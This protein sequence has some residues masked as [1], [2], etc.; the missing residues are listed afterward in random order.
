MTLSL[1]IQCFAVA[2]IGWALQTTLKMRALQLK[3]RAA[4]V[5]FKPVDYFKEDWLSIT[6]AFLTIVLF[7]FFVSEF[8]NWQTWIISYV[9]IGFAFVGYTGSDIASRLFSVV[10]TRINAAI[11]YKTT[12]SD[13]QTGTL[14]K[15]TPAVPIAKK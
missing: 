9:R 11:D 10:N 13:T 8:L 2:L 7:L 6:A 3:A 14:D 12:I 15:P 4:N 1:Y 5:I